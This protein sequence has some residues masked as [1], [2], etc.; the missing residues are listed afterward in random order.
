MMSSHRCG[1][2]TGLGLRTGLI[3]LT[4]VAAL[5]GIGCKRRPHVAGTVGA[6]AVTKAWTAEG[7]DTTGVVNVEADP[8]AAGACSQGTVSGVDVL[9]CEYENDESLSSGEQKI[10]AGWDEE[11][12]PT[13]VLVRTTQP[14]R[15]ILAMADR[16]KADPNGRTIARLAASFQARTEQ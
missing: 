8:W 4:L 5:G 3:T 2:G 10:N 16:S 12:V 1:V 7:F 13:A 11:S 9:I 6:E 14:S 15:T